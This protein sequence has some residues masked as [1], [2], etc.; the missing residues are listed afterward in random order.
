MPNFAVINNNQVINLIIC[1]SKELAESITNFLCIEYTSE[2]PTD[3]GWNYDGTK[4]VN[5]NAPI[6]SVEEPE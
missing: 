4:F 2:N 1:E 6:V 3:I 5:P